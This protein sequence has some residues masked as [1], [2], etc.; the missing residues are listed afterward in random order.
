MQHLLYHRPFVE[1]SLLNPAPASLTVEDVIQG[2][3]LRLHPTQHI[4]RSLAPVLPAP[5]IPALE[6]RFS[7]AGQ[8]H[9]PHKPGSLP[10]PATIGPN[11]GRTDHGCAHSGPTTH[12]NGAK[13]P[14]NRPHTGLRG[15]LLPAYRA[16][17]E[18]IPGFGG[19]PRRPC[20]QNTGLWGKSTGLRGKP[21]TWFIPPLSS[22]VPPPESRPRPS[23]TFH[24]QHERST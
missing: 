2:A 16:F 21:G 22:R 17:G 15:K 12:Q 3:A 4:S 23:P 1:T 11:H 14:K 6:E 18:A 5:A 7:E 13:P 10:C 24:E 20:A 8:A 9:L 19:S